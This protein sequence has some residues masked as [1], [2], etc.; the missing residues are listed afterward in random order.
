VT[1]S[2]SPCCRRCSCISRWC[3]RSGRTPNAATGTASRSGSCR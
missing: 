2:R 3:F 1:R